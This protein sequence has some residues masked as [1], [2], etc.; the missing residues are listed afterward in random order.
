MAKQSNVLKS[1]A[2][3]DVRWFFGSGAAAL[4]ARA[5]NYGGAGVRVDADDGPLDKRTAEVARYRRVEAGLRRLRAADC[6]TLERW[7]MPRNLDTH[8]ED[9]RKAEERRKS[10]HIPLYKAFGELVVVVVTL[11]SLRAAHAE[12]TAKA[13]RPP[14]YLE[15]VCDQYRNGAPV[16][17][18]SRDKAEELVKAALNA[19]AAVVARDPAKKRAEEQ[20]EETKRERRSEGQRRRRIREIEEIEAALGVAS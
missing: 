5:Q 8:V 20:R 2:A 19:F 7:A 13:K 18:E 12:A 3:N 15:W 6:R 10:A 16:I 9:R 17:A 1:E 4:G 14:P 11:D